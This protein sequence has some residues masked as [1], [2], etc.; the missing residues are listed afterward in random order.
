M[1]IHAK[2]CQ[3]QIY[4]QKWS[5]HT[6]CYEHITIYVEVMQNYGQISTS[7]NFI[8]YLLGEFLNLHILLIRFLVQEMAEYVSRP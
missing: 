7:Y 6:I 8:F 3:D 1:V 2:L 5:I 4:D